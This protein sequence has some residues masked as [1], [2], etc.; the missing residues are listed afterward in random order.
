MVEEINSPVVKAAIDVANANM[1][2]SPG[3]ALERA[4][5]HLVHVHV[6]DNRG[7]TWTHSSIGEGDIDFVGVADKLNEIGFAGVSIMEIMIRED[8]DRRLLDSKGRLERLGWQA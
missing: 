7:Q 3:E 6:S 8:V 4:K 2:E 5:N 1:V